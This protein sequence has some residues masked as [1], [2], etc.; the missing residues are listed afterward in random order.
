VLWDRLDT[1]RDLP[2]GRNN[3]YHTFKMSKTDKPS[4]ALFWGCF[5]ALVTTAFGFITR[6]FLLDDPSITVDLLGLDDAEVGMFKGI[7]V[8]PFAISIILFSLII[9]KVGYK[10]AMIFAATSQ[11]IWGIMGIYGLSV[12]DTNPELAKSLLFWGG[13]ILA[14][15]N[16]TV[17]AFINPVVA[18][19]FDKEKT[20]WLNILHAGWPGGLVIAGIAVILMGGA[21]WEVKLALIFIPAIVY[22]VVLIRCQFPVQERVAAGVSYR[23]MLGEFGFGGAAVVSILMFLQL[24]QAIPG[25][26]TL[27]MIVCAAM[28][29]GLGV[30]TKSLGRP[31]MFILILL[32][33]PL[34]TTEIGTDGWISGVMANAVKF[35]AGWILVYTS[36]IMM[37]LRFYA[38]PIVH[39]LSPLPLLILSSLLAIAG[40]FALAGASGPALIFAAAT[41]Y[42][43]GKTFFWPTMLGIVSEQTPKGGALTLNSVSGIGMLAVGVLGFP[44]IGSLKEA[45]TVSEVAALKEANDIPGLIVDNKIAADALEDK[46]IYYGTIKYQSLKADKVESLLENQGEET[47]KAIEGAKAGAGQKALASMTIFPFIMLIAYIAL[48]FYFKSKGGYKPLELTS[49]TH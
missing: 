13:L 43:L 36:L 1:L 2:I 8:W 49:D 24:D 19:L 47:K 18:T 31:L 26:T 17:E 23:E 22:L 25:Y 38:G 32:M 46:E 16:G 7:Q 20:K 28:A 37:I 27:W 6:M 10:F 30:Y 42:A 3:E 29:I 4:M 11:I 44:Y 12:A 40:L 34:A 21:S 41:L 48:Y 33:T 9:D 39:R 15:G 45:K 14:L 35:H 5:I